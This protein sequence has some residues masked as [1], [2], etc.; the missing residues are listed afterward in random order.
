MIT[1]E[2]LI[3]VLSFASLWMVT[4]VFIQNANRYQMWSLLMMLLSSI[5]LKYW[6]KI[7]G[8]S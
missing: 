5:A 8:T 2:W 7:N 4:L 1:K 6:E 3:K